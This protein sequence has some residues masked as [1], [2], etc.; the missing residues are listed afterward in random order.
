MGK[1]HRNL[2]ASHAPESDSSSDV[3]QTSD[4]ILSEHI[5]HDPMPDDNPLP[6][7]QQHYPQECHSSLT[8]QHKSAGLSDADGFSDTSSVV[9]PSAHQ[10]RCARC[11]DSKPD[12][13]PH[14]GEKYYGSPSPV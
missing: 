10:L 7:A 9:S 11:D 3:I 6:F 12:R 4:A 8:A 14:P 13:S 5:R 1:P 2:P